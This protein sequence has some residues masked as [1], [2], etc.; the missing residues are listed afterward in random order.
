M[1]VVV[2][3]EARL[4]RQKARQ[5]HYR[6]MHY[7]PEGK[8]A[9]AVEVSHSRCPLLLLHLLLHLRLHLHLLFHLR[10]R[11]PVKKLNNSLP[12]A[13]VESARGSTTRR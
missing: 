6:V 7:H 2:D 13:I 11:Q 5:A 4:R 12:I 9:V 10:N 3:R 1:A 8:V